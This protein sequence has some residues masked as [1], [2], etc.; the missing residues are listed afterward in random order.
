MKFFRRE[1]HEL[2]VVVLRFAA[3][4]L[5]LW[6]GIDKWIHP[7]A[8]YGWMTSSALAYLPVSAETVLFAAGAAEFALG[9][10]LVAGKWLQAASALAGAFLAL[11]AVTFG[12]NDVTVRDA[13][14]LGACLALFLHANAT[15]KRPVSQRTVSL[16]CSSYVLFLFLYGVLYLRN[17]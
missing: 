8:W 17:T 9:A 1:Q 16:V 3:G 13:S 6:L 2:T 7:D 4:S 14:V 5:F 11:V 10:A 12:P 15:A